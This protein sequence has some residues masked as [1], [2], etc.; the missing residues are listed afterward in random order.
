[1]TSSQHMAGYNKITGSS[2]R[3][4]PEKFPAGTGLIAF[5]LFTHFSFGLTKGF[6]GYPESL[7]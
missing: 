6:S 3:S 7:K 4:V 5:D 2:N 1:M